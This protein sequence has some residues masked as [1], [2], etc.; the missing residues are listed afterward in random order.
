LPLTNT[1]FTAADLERSLMAEL[2]S[3]GGELTCDFQKQAL[4]RILR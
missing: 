3:R 1:E 4:R 2:S